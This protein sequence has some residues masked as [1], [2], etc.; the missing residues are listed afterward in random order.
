MGSYDDPVLERAIQ[1]FKYEG[2]K[3]LKEPLGILLALYLES[4]IG[5]FEINIRNFIVTPVPLHSKRLRDRGFNQAFLLAEKVSEHF[6][7]E[8]DE[9]L[10]RIK[11]NAPQVGIQGRE[12]R[13]KNM[14][15]V[16]APRGTNEI[17]GKGII[18]VDDVF[19]SGATMN[20]AVR[21]L[22]KSGARQVIALVLAKA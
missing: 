8:T 22:K 16:F 7:I 12:A 15:E 13:L 3:Q 4:M 5:R 20:E 19:T 11:N 1:G 2:I 21:V 14:K 10:V 9:L 18:V 6:S 17:N